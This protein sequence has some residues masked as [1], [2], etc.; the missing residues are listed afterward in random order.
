MHELT[1]LCDV[2]ACAIIYNGSNE[3]PE[4]W[5]DNRDKVRE[6]IDLYK[7]NQ[8]AGKTYS[9]SDFYN[10]KKR[11]VEEEIGVLRK[12]NN[13]AK[14]PMQGFD[15]LNEAQLR[16]FAALLGD[17][18]KRVNSRIDELKRKS[19]TDENLKNFVVNQE[20]FCCYP[21]PAD[22]QQ[23]NQ[24]G[25]VYQNHHIPCFQFTTLYF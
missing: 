6:L 22:Q 18:L 25:S 12:R 15:M 8:P 17:K 5:P 2:K 13:Q 1:T 3:E 19:V 16:E 11:K 21:G 23:Y 4:I 20:G 14:Y 24:L 10:D 7:S 9:L